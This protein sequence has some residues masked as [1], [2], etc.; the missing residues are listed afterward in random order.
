MRGI[1]QWKCGTAAT[2]ANKHS[3]RNPVSS[4]LRPSWPLDQ[5]LDAF[6][7]VRSRLR[8]TLAVG[9][10][11]VTATMSSDGDMEPVIILSD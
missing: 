3:G 5:F 2:F 6:S 1:D 8:M 7:A 11:P 9:S 4:E 10:N